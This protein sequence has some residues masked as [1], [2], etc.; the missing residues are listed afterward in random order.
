MI[1]F[2]LWPTLAFVMVMLCW[3]T[4]AASFLFHKKPPSPPDKK[5]D[6]WS[7]V[8][9]ALQGTG[10]AIVWVVRRAWFTPILSLGKLAEITVAIL[11]MA[12][13]AGSVWLCISAIRTLGQQWS[14]AARVVEGHELVTQGPYSV[15]RNPIYTG[16]LGMLL[17]TGL[18]VSH[19]LGL[20]I[21]LVVFSIGTAIRVRSEAA[22]LRETFGQEFEEYARRVPAVIPYVI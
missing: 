16:M 9:I 1:H 17:A 11:A 18:A 19:W 5:R 3:F 10:F 8:G 2:Q 12:L 14:L 4:F 13:A 21:S 7:F 20:L 6:Q 22:L 15:V